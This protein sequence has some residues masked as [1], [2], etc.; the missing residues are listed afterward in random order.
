MK[1]ELL[2]LLKDKLPSLARDIYNPE[3]FAHFVYDDDEV[4]I[5]TDEDTQVIT[6]HFAI[7][8]FD[9]QRCVSGLKLDELNEV[10]KTLPVAYKTYHISYA[11]F[12]A[13]LIHE[14]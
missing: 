13:S 14:N 3:L 1:T 4:T 2:E 12:L 10:V 6:Y 11:M 7:R 9:K 8:L 5:E